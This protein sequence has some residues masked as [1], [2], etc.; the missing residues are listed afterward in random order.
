MVQWGNVFMIKA[1]RQAQALVRAGKAVEGK[2]I[3]AMM[4]EFN[5]SEKK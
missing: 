2:A 5:E 3:D 4:A 1:D